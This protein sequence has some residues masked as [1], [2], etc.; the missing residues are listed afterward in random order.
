LNAIVVTQQE[1][2]HEL[3]VATWPGLGVSSLL[4][5]YPVSEGLTTSSGFTP[6]SVKSRKLKLSKALSTEPERLFLRNF[7]PCQKIQYITV[8][9]IPPIFSFMLRAHRHDIPVIFHQVF[10]V[11]HTIPEVEDVVL[12]HLKKA[13]N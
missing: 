4:L 8:H 13:K 7:P 1:Q 11:C 10:Q 3:T 12:K 5:K 9:P 2:F 6:T